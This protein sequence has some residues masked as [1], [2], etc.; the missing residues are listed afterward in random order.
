MEYT[1]KMTAGA[2]QE[3]QIVGLSPNAWHMGAFKI[4]KRMLLPGMNILVVKWNDGKNPTVIQFGCVDVDIKTKA[5]SF[6]SVRK[7]SSQKLSERGGGA[8]RLMQT[9]GKL[10]NRMQEQL[11]EHGG[12]FV[13]CKGI[14]M[15][16]VYLHHEQRTSKRKTIASSFL[17]VVPHQATNTKPVMVTTVAAAKA[18]LQSCGATQKIWAQQTMGLLTMSIIA[19]TCGIL[20]EVW[21]FWDV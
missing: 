2:F 18:I 15:K 11:S 17:R 6:M 8:F 12:L 10:T 5:A 21:F 9:S 3:S 1:K 20:T 16:H 19:K 13:P 7:G 14:R 4:T